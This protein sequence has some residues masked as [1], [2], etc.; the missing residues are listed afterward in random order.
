MAILVRKKAHPPLQWSHNKCGKS[1][2]KK[3]THPPSI[4]RNL[5]KNTNKPDSQISLPFAIL[6]PACGYRFSAHHVSSSSV[7]LSSFHAYPDT[8]VRVLFQDLILTSFKGLLQLS[9]L[10]VFFNPGLKL[11]SAH[12][13][14][15]P[16]CSEVNFFFLSSHL[17]P[18]LL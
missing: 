7:I 12:L 8:Q 13:L 17:L 5:L 16:N 6:I 10:N 14:P 11:Y 1:G 2:Y 3:I 15:G 18:K 9:K 4:K